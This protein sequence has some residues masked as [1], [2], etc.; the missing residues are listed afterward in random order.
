MAKEQLV[1]VYFN[2][3]VISFERAETHSWSTFGGPTEAN[4]S[5][6]EHGPKPLHMIAQLSSEHLSGL[7]RSHV[8]DLPLIYGM[9]YDGCE[10]EYRVDIGSKVEIRKL[11][12]RQSSDDWPY[13]N[14]P[15]LLPYVPLRIGSTRSSTY[16]EF[17]QAFP[18]MPEQPT[19]LIVVVPAPAT[20]GFSLWGRHGELA[21]ILFECDLEDR[22]VYASNRCD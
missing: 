14:Y 13:R 20:L 17:A 12:P 19:E 2:S 10:L 16:E 4:F 22:I 18:N 15:P 21:I 8:Y 7:G 1:F 3:T 9:C 5:G 6:I 11:S